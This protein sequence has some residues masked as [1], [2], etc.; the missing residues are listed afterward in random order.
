MTAF[1]HDRATAGWSL[2]IDFGTTN[3]AAATTDGGG[4]PRV[5]EIEGSRYFPSM[6]YRDEAGQLLTG[7]TAVRQAAVF[8]D[9]AERVPKRAL[10]AGTEVVLGGQAVPV[11]ELVAAVLGRVYAEA[12][13]YYGGRPPAIVVLT[14]PALW[15]ETQRGRLRDAA[16]KAGISDPV[17]VSEPV[18][19]ASWYARP[20]AG[21][22][23]AVFDLGGGTL[24]TAVLHASGMSYEIAGKPG[25]NANLGGED[26]DELLLDR[27][28][29][30]ARERD[31]AEWD[32]LF[33]M[34][35]ARSR[36]DMALVRADV[37][38][39]KEALSE[40]TVFDL[41]VVGFAEEFRLTRP[42]FE[43][44]IGAQVDEAVDEMQR[45]IAAAG[46]ADK[47]AGCYLT[48][49]SSRIPMIAARLAAAVEVAPQ[50]RDDPKAVVALGAL[51]VY[52][53]APN[54]TPPAPVAERVRPAQPSSPA[55]DQRPAGETIQRLSTADLA[56]EFLRR[57]G[58]GAER[59]ASAVAESAA[60]LGRA[61]ASGMAHAVAAAGA[62]VSRVTAGMPAAI[63]RARSGAR[64]LPASPVARGA[65]R[66]VSTGW[67][68]LRK[69]PPRSK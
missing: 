29:D 50:L 51:S 26:F 5:L 1:T 47:L 7:R 45:T 28:S 56:R 43:S 66:V 3:T 13:R 8:P 52:A 58:A 40:H 12:V 46:V 48:G 31:A 34:A 64:R 41:A 57:T 11:T 4:S 69:K 23:V 16:I 19:A 67:K 63:A 21:G 44:L 6:V 18:A 53:V 30:L 42:E 20:S 68:R 10:I 17:F 22:V 2:A 39:A 38:A 54:P 33:S 60:K 15:N 14:H 24:D 62:F 61:V 32:G 9:R 27:V 65:D 55:R 36:R 49:G 37:T 25:G 59:T 35:S